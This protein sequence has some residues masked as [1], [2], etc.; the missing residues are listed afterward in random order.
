MRRPGSPE[1]P[2]RIEKRVIAIEE[3]ARGKF[4][5]D[6]MPGLGLVPQRGEI[7]Q[8]EPAIFRLGIQAVIPVHR[9]F[10]FEF[11]SW[12]Q[13]RRDMIRPELVPAH[14]VAIAR[15]QA[16]AAAEINLHMR[17]PGIAT[18]GDYDIKRRGRAIKEAIARP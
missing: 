16:R 4:T 14:A 3:K 15:S 2:D 18:G 8:S 6:H 7:E 10:E 9:P 5:A 11:R 17:N 13:Y 1:W 12:P